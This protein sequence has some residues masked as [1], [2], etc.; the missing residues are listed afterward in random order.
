MRVD[1]PLPPSPK[2]DLLPDP[3]G[4]STSPHHTISSPPAVTL[5]ARSAN[6]KVGRE[7]ERVVGCGVSQAE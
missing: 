1:L 7:G 3:V 6:D 4:L 2:L 5:A